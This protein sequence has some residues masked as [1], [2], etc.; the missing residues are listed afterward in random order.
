MKD[1]AYALGYVERDGRGPAEPLRIVAATAGKKADGLDLQMDRV[2]LERFERNPLVLYGH[3]AFGRENLPIG[4]SERTWTE[5]DRLMMDL[6]F[7]S[8]DQFAAEVERKYRGGFLNAF[9]IGFDPINV[10]DDG[11]P[12][13]WELMEVSAVPLPLD[14]NAV[15]DDGRQQ[16]LVAVRTLIRD[17]GACLAMAPDAV[18][19]AIA[20]GVDGIPQ[21]TTGSPVAMRWRRLTLLRRP[22]V[23]PVV[24]FPAAVESEV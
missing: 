13:R 11:V 23:T 1:R 4:R 6:A 14:P 24:S 19:A 10:D 18:L 12:E 3:F 22:R 7:D 2:D 21:E 8:G 17:A 20:E 15:V 9:S 5:G 16:V